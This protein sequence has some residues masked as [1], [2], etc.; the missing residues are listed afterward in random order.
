[1]VLAAETGLLLASIACAK[2]NFS[3]QEQQFRQFCLSGK[4]RNNFGAP[5][6]PKLLLTQ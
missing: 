3:A 2:V 6:P 1:M 5:A 4:N